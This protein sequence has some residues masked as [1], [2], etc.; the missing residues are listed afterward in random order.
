[1]Y[2]VT[3]PDSAVMPSLSAC[4]DIIQSPDVAGKGPMT[5]PVP[6]TDPLPD[7]T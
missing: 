1:M 6:A 2:E 4:S 3:D 7:P 5:P